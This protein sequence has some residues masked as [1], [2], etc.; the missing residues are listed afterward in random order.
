MQQW[1]KL[2]ELVAAWR[3]SNYKSNF[4]ALAEIL[5]HQCDEDGRLL[6]LREP[7]FQALETYWYLRTRLNT[8]KF[9]DLYKALYDKRSERFNALGIEVGQNVQRLPLRRAG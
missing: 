9:L 1:S 2:E 3:E 4:P 8:P 6:F 7:Q 5:L